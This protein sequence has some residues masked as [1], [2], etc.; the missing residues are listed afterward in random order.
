[1]GHL[2]ED[3]K[4][5]AYALLLET[6][7]VMLD[8]QESPVPLPKPAADAAAAAL[9]LPAASKN[10]LDLLDELL[11]GEIDDQGF[12]GIENSNQAAT[13]AAALWRTADI[14][15]DKLPFNIT[16]KSPPGC[17]ILTWWREKASAFPLVA[18]VAKEVL[19]VQPPLPLVKS[20]RLFS[21][22]RR[23]SSGD[24]ATISPTM[25]EATVRIHNNQRRKAKAATS[26]IRV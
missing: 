8:A 1:M 15:T 17:D 23:I 6:I 20:E 2:S 12:Q 25:L 10:S 11:A 5:R 22:A 16:S 4:N 3:D 7:E 14:K 13:I 18:M 26:F 24:R 9:A 21:T 19:S